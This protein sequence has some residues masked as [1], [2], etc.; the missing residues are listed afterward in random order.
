MASNNTQGSSHDVRKTASNKL[1]QSSTHAHHICDTPRSLRQ[2]PSMCFFTHLVEITMRSLLNQ[3]SCITQ[4]KPKLRTIHQEPSVETVSH[5][6]GNE[7]FRPRP[8]IIN[9]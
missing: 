3:P 8:L 6:L 5:D 7:P 1:F 2:D 9:S 4:D